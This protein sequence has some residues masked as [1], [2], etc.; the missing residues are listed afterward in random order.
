MHAYIRTCIHTRTRT[1]T[2]THM[3]TQ[4]HTHARVYRHTC[5][6]TNTC[7][8]RHTHIKTHKYTHSYTYVHTYT[9]YMYTQ[10]QHT[11]HRWRVTPCCVQLAINTTG[12]DHPVSMTTGEPHRLTDNLTANTQSIVYWLNGRT[13]SYRWA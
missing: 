1:H 12:S 13:I 3:Y 8:H 10:L 2:H 9:Q 5:T 6:C 4:I 7:T 11:T